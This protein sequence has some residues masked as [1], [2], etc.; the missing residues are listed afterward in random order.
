M[1]QSKNNH[2]GHP[3]TRSSIPSDRQ[4][5]IGVG[6]ATKGEGRGIKQ[7][8]L[9]MNRGEGKGPGAGSMGRGDPR[10]LSRTPG[11]D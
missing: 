6:A 3:F 11:K 10:P 8:S 7:T 5:A 9:A 4:S 2:P 1:A